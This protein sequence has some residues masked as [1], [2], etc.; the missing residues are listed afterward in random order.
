MTIHNYDYDYERMAGICTYIRLKSDF[1]ILNDY[2]LLVVS[3]VVLIIVIVILN[4]T[5]CP[6]CRKKNALCAAKNTIYLL[7]NR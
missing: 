4:L 2:L 7:E 1:N 3:I 5:L 6:Q